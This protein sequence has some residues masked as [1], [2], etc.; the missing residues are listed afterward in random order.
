VLTG[1]TVGRGGTFSKEP[2]GGLRY[3]RNGWEPLIYMFSRSGFPYVARPYRDCGMFCYD[4]LI[5]DANRIH[6]IRSANGGGGLDFLSTLLPLLA[7]ELR[8]ARCRMK[9]KTAGRPVSD[10]EW[11]GLRAGDQTEIERWVAEVEHAIG[12]FDV[13]AFLGARD[14]ALE[15]GATE[16]QQRFVDLLEEDLR[17][18][19]LGVERS[20]QKYLA[21]VLLHLREGLNAAVDFGGLE[22]RSHDYFFG[23]FAG[24]LRRLAIGPQPERSEEL[25]ALIRAGVVKVELGPN[26]VVKR[27]AD[28]AFDIASR[29]L[30]RATSCVVSTLIQA[31][32]SFPSI[33]QSDSLLLT[34]LA[35][36]GR[37]RKHR[38][39]VRFDGGVEID[40][41]HHPIG[42]LGQVETSL[43]VLGPLC[44]GS[45]YYNTYVPTTVGWSRPFI[46]A[47]VVV[48]QILHDTGLTMLGQTRVE[49]EGGYYVFS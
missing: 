43:F 47:A 17:E 18:S 40:R 39:D 23:D 1:L 29:N 26:P 31:Q 16:Y 12:A 19:R 22:A 30:A 42:R 48:G 36:A 46:E 44:E 7:I 11:A 21:E 24:M 28:G 6:S 34:D 4:P 14:L 13:A 33:E 25:V 9:L 35:R 15:G 37:V 27:R 49:H 45:V 2:D 32:S 20:E 38:D 3:Q 8:A 5:F 10:D 41:W